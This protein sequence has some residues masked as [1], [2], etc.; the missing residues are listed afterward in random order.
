MKKLFLSS[1]FADVY[2]LFPDFANENPKGKS[3][4][5]IPTAS[6]LEEIKFYVE[7]DKKALKELGL[8]IDE[9]EITN[10]TSKE[11]SDKLTNNDYIFV[12][13]GNS[14]YLLQE[15][16]KTGT[17]KIISRQINDGK[18]YI[19]SSAGSVILSPNIEY[20]KKM[21][22]CTKAQ[23]LT[24]YNALSIVNFYPVPHYTNYPFE[25]IVEEIIKQYESKIKLIPITNSQVITVT[26]DEEKIE[27]N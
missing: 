1:S 20:I 12:A 25:E 9:L 22:D 4:T 13:G 17:D 7:D 18:I 2:N 23:E 24:D 21:D 3:I 6:I 19:G 8:K 10:A 5:F 15:M 16:K 26:E 14:F 11:I 27:S